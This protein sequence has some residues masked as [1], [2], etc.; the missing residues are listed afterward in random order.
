MEIESCD[1]LEVDH[2]NEKGLRRGVTIEGLT[3]ADGSIIHDEPINIL[4][5]LDVSGDVMIDLNRGDASFCS[6]RE[7]HRVV[8][9]LQK[10][11]KELEEEVIELRYHPESP[12]IREIGNKWNKQFYQEK[13]E[14]K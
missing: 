4:S 1:I 9:G 5:D 14:N 6:L 13:N 8:E 12:Y 10:K 3:F 2:I 11:V 7:L